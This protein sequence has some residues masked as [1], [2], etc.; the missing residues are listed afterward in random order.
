MAFRL[1]LVGKLVM[2]TAKFQICMFL[3]GCSQQIK[4][5]VRRILYHESERPDPL[6][7]SYMFRLDL[8]YQILRLRFLQD[9][10]S[11]GEIRLVQIA[12]TGARQ[13]VLLLVAAPMEFTPAKAVSEALLL[14]ASQTVQT[15]APLF[16]SSNKLT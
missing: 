3:I 13:V 16:V 9:L 11:L 7:Q 5:T 2:E 4:I 14:M 6:T 10:I 15:V 8:L 12:I 1:F